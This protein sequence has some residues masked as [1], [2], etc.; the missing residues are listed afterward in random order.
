MIKTK[1]ILLS[2]IASVVFIISLNSC[3]EKVEKQKEEASLVVA[4]AQIV[5][6]DQAKSMYDNY[7]ERRSPLI[8]RYED[9]INGGKEK[10]DVARYVSYD[11]ET[12]KQYLAFIEQEAAKANVEISGLRFYLSNYPDKA[13]FDNGDSIKHPRQNS[14]MLS[15]TLKKGERDY[16]FYIRG[17]GEYE[18]AVLLT[19][20]FGELGAEGMGNNTNKTGNSYASFIPNLNSSATTSTSFFASTSLTMNRGSGAPPPYN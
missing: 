2:S 13:I 10:F 3:A 20:S 16:I 11:Y 8:Q 12:I 7:S 9:S 6:I 5:L 15:P 1:K 4:P 17:T 19:D 14:V 18:Q